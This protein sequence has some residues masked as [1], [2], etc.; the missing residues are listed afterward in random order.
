MGQII[1]LNCF[2]LKSG[3]PIKRNTFDCQIL[4]FEYETLFDRCLVVSQ[5]NKQVT[6]RTYPKMILIQPTVVNEQLTLSAPGQSD[7][8]LDLNE[9]RK[10]P[11]KSKVQLWDS[12]V[13]GI[14]AGD[15]VANWLSEY[16]V[17]IPNVF[18]LIYYPYE[19]PTKPKLSMDK[20][21]NYNAK[22]VGVYHDATS[23]MLINQ[24][25]VDELNSHL[26]HV[27]KPLQFRP[28]IVVK[29]PNAYEEDN[30]QWIRFGENVVFRGV[31]PCTR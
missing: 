13:L 8:T 12:K 30:W 25:S 29:G 15:D 17:K 10:K 4:G 26:D 18:R 28:N 11:V 21:Y 1:D 9:L 22:D 27:T 23:Y 20:Q 24:G 19:Y 7:I 16:I 31:R 5:N 3:A 2:P 14:D 6:A